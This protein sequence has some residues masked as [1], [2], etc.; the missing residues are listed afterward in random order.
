[1]IRLFLHLLN[2]AVNFRIDL[3]VEWLH[4][5]ICVQRHKQI[6]YDWHLPTHFIFELISL[7]HSAIKLTEAN[8][9]RLF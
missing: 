3:E 5:S 7:K 4:H 2:S 9:S 6:I 8:L 1:M